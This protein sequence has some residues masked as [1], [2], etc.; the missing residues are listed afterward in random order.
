[1]STVGILPYPIVPAAPRAA[2]YLLTGGGWALFT[3][4][5]GIEAPAPAHEAPISW[6]LQGFYSPLCPHGRSDLLAMSQSMPKME[7]RA[8]TP[9]FH[10]ISHDLLDPL[11]V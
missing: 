7:F 3:K 4:L 2:L 6:M 8:I 10:A 5:I 11:S 1:L 9:P